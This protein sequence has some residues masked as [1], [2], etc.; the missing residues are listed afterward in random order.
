MQIHNHHFISESL[1]RSSTIKR[2]VSKRYTTCNNDKILVQEY[3]KGRDGRDGRDGLPGPKGVT[4]PTGPA[5]PKGDI[6]PKGDTGPRGV[7]SG[8][9]VYVR[10]GHDSCPDTGA[11]LVYTGR[12]G[13]TFA[14]QKGGGGDAQC[15][16]LDPNYLNT[17]SGAQNWAF[18]Y[19]AEYEQTNGLVPN[20]QDMDVVCAVCYVPTRNTVYMLPAKYTCPTENTMAI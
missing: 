15:L 10:W 8:G 20:T 19:G 12:V 3:L 9:V 18:I 4:G 7:G 1:N 17:I 14:I 11:Q 13:A 6:G 2:D 5:G 16:P